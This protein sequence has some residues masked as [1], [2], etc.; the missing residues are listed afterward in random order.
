MSVKPKRDPR[1]DPKPGDEV[2]F[3]P[4]WQRERYAVI[5]RAGGNVQYQLGP[6]R[7]VLRCTLEQ[8]REWS[9]GGEVVNHA[10]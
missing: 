6:M 5:G 10:G 9:A 7:A 4:Q 3:G 1:I 2:M 8:W